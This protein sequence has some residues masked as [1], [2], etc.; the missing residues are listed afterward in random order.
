MS[1][2]LEYLRPKT[3]DEALTLLRRP[4]MRTVPLAGG[5]WLVPRLR[6]DVDVPE[7]LEEPV[8][9]VVDLADLGLS[10]IELEGQPGDGSLRLGAT[11]TLEQMADSAVCRQLASGILA[12]AAQREAPINQRNAAT[13]AGAVLG[14][15]S[16]SELLLALLAL[17]AHAVVN[18]GQPRAVPLNELLADLPGQLGGGLVTEIKLPWPAE[19]AR[20]GL[21]RVARTPTD[22]PIVAA[23]ALVG[24]DS[25]RVVVGGVTSA[26]L[27][28]RLEAG[29]DLEPVLDAALEDV[30]MLSDWQ[31]SD[32]YRRAMALVLGRRAL[33]QASGAA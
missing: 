24:G 1:A 12:Q 25:R 5:A 23:A 27:L 11:T 30:P 28:L 18:A 17:A 21:A 26:P 6:G 32:E 29:V 14:A 3:L 10:F 19:T 20:G 2:T 22:Q 16:Q 7:P 31:G 15:P 33:E 4:G 9:A 13:V 8:D